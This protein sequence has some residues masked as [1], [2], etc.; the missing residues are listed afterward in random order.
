[1]NNSPD[2]T[3]IV[4]RCRR[5]VA[6]IWLAMLLVPSGSVR[7]NEYLENAAIAVFGS[8]DLR[9]HAALQLYELADVGMPLLRDQ[10]E[11]F[12]RSP[13]PENLPDALLPYLGL[14]VERIDAGKRAIIA[15]AL[16]ISMV[17]TL[18]DFTDL[19]GDAALVVDILMRTLT[20]SF[21]ASPDPSSENVVWSDLTNIYR[22][23]FS[24]PMR[25]PTSYYRYVMTI[26][27]VG[28][29]T[30]MRHPGVMQQLFGK[31]GPRL[32]ELVV[33]SENEVVFGPLCQLAR[34][35]SDVQLRADIAN[36]FAL[37]ASTKAR[38]PETVLLSCLDVL[39]FA[40]DDLRPLALMSLFEGSLAISAE[41]LALA[42]RKVEVS[43]LLHNDD[44]V[45]SR[46]T[47]HFYQSIAELKLTPTRILD[48]TKH[49]YA[50]V[51]LLGDKLA[52]ERPERSADD[53]LGL[54]ALTE[55]SAQ[56]KVFVSAGAFEALRS[57]FVG[58][59]T[60]KAIS[61]AILSAKSCFSDGLGIPV[62]LPPV[63][64]EKYEPS[65]M[66][67]G[68]Y[69]DYLVIA[70]VSTREAMAGTHAPAIP[71]NVRK[72]ASVIGDRFVGLRARRLGQAIRELLRAFGAKQVEDVATCWFTHVCS[73][74]L[75]ELRVRHQAPEVVLSGH[76]IAELGSLFPARCDDLAALIELP[77]QRGCSRYFLPGGAYRTNL[78]L[79]RGAPRTLWDRAPD[80]S[81]FF[82]DLSTGGALPRCLGP[83]RTEAPSR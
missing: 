79:A 68:D 51:R 54:E 52:T 55:L 14:Y 15:D 33:A 61:E 53:Q 78:A 64:L 16:L 67:L 2:L 5:F 73:A 20:Q 45:N 29:Y 43:G 75:V 26:R 25:R 60:L 12:T 71:S 1:M 58:T 82:C 80:G 24:I 62:L 72:L 7:A 56:C 10:M 77:G 9:R 37:Y 17:G 35:Q 70:S 39:K 31:A 59:Q 66:A 22:T 23:Y 11:V 47:V 3:G 44:T 69:D 36:L 41:R 46:V 83:S 21:L 81:K 57:G 63:P 34:A 30:L 32:A 6:T 76:P 8:D 28:L 38:D 50:A 65:G 40:T 4:W 74:G 49:F 19:E 18:R 27:T 13:K 42:L 48:E